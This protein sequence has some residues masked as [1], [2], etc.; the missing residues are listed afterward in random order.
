MEHVPTGARKNGADFELHAKMW[1]FSTAT[2]K[3]KVPCLVT[4]DSPL[5]LRAERVQP[6]HHPLLGF[7]LN[8]RSCASY[9]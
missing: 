5:F 3:D 8:S 6:R 7:A 2:L 4:Q 1:S 9:S